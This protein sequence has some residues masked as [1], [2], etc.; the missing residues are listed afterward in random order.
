MKSCKEAMA[1]SAIRCS[2][3]STK[4]KPRDCGGMPSLG[5]SMPA[6][7]PKELKICMISCSVTNGSRFPTY[8]RGLGTSVCRAAAAAAS[9]LKA[10][11]LWCCCM[12]AGIDGNPSAASAE[13]CALAPSG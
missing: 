5:K 8:T 9:R 1:R 3:N 13:A 10:A 11:A 2:R 12:A 7:T 6:T 4:Q